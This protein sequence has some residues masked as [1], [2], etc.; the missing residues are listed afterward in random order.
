MLRELVARHDVPLP[1][2]MVERYLDSGLEEM[3]RRNTRYGHQASA[4]E[5]AEY[6]EAGRPHAEKALRGMLLL[7]AVRRQEEIKL[8]A[9]AVDARIEAI[10]AENGFPVDDYR[11]FV[12]SGDGEERERIAYDLLERITYDFLLARAEIEDVPADTDVL[13]SGKE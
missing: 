1:P 11:E 8:E 6:R 10:A 12:D 13:D 5:D 4:E 3:H 9:E 7:E 2:S